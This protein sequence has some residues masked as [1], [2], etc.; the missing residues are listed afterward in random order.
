MKARFTFALLSL[1]IV[2]LLGVCAWF[3]LQIFDTQV[4]EED[5]NPASPKQPE[6]ISFTH[7]EIVTV[8][9]SPLPEPAK[10]MKAP[11]RPQPVTPKPVQ[12][13]AQEEP[14]PDH[15]GLVAQLVGK[16]YRTKGSG[17]RFELS[18]SDKVFENDN[19]ET[20]K[21]SRLIIVFIDNTQLSL[22]EKTRCTIDEYLFDKS[23]RRDSSFG[24]RLVEGVCRVVT[25]MITTL[26]PDRFKVET[27]M[28]T[29]GIRG[30][31]L[32]FRA[33]PEEEQVYVLGLNAKESV[34][35]S[36]TDDGAVIR[37]IHSGD[38]NKDIAIT[39]EVINDQGTVVTITKGLGRS[40]RPV[41]PEELRTITTDTSPLNSVKHTPKVQPNSTVFVITPE[42]RGGGDQNQ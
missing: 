8:K 26:N 28:A 31:E 3:T 6:D 38:E 10:P 20:D 13:I 5:F 9:P 42:E 19:I 24:L 33:K 37:D 11:P 2:A 27:R 18:Q 39:S 22:G 34:V 41:S 36:S 7:E 32:A 23:A 40:S 14:L 29:I 12:T 1:A 25:G 35:V 15:A 21:D 16:A 4:A 30:C 17:A